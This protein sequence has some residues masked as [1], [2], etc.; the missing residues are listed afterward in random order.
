M[1][2]KRVYSVFFW[3]IIVSHFVSMTACNKLII[4]DG[5]KVSS[6]YL[7]AEKAYFDKRYILAKKYYLKVLR[8][9]P[10]NVDVLF[11]LGN[12]NMREKK[13][14]EARDYYSKVLKIKP[15]HE[16]S[17]Y[18]IAILHLYQA[19]KHMVYYT[20]N[21]DSVRNPAINDLLREVDTYS[22]SSDINTSSS[23]AKSD[24]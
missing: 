6:L 15:G 7:K 1:T 18:N 3:C 13:W 5:E 12:V 17:R 16:K 4:N 8:N 23:Y 11:R 20:Q 22:K 24:D 10:G 9:N 14:S 19:K 21:F 2:C